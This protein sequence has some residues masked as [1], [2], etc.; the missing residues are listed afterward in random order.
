MKKVILSAM[1]LTVTSV[2][3]FAQSPRTFHTIA[4][5]WSDINISGKIKGKF[6]WQIENQQRREDMQGDYNSATTTGNPYHNLNQNVFRPYIH[7]Q[8]NPNIRLSLMPLGWI[9]SQRFKDGQPSAFFAELRVAPQAIVTQTFGRVRFDNR[10]RYEFRWIGNNQASDN[11]SFLYG[12]DFRTTTFR[13]RFRNQLK[14]TVPLN[15]AKMDDK[16]LY[17][18]GYNE[19]FVNMGQKVANTNIFDQNRVLLGLGYKFNKFF[20]VEAGFM[21]QSIFRFNNTNKDNVDRNNILQV[22]FAVTNVDAMFKKKK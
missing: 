2:C 6:S 18:Q 12:G 15:H 11:K 19:L 13:M 1:L 20:A 9:G 22:N 14:L 4:N 8:A 16:T 17:V 10:M 7:Y 3:T 21:R 5:G